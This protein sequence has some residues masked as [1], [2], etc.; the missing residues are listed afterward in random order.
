VLIVLKF[1]GIYEIFPTHER[2]EAMNEGK[3]ENDE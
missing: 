2:I 3:S 1:E